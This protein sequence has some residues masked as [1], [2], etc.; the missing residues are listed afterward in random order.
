MA[1]EVSAF[2]PTCKGGVADP[3]T[4]YVE[5]CGGHRPDDKGLD[6]ALV[7]SSDAFSLYA[8]QESE[9]A[10]NR[11]ACALIHGTRGSE[12]CGC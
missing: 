9:G 11:N 6:D 2:C 12:L 4:N 5:F 1:D 7:V 3:I 10:Q 8:T